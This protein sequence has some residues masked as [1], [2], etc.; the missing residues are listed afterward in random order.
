MQYVSSLPPVVTPTGNREQAVSGVHAVKPV[1]ARNNPALEV[2][3]HPPPAE[4]PH[5]GAVEHRQFLHAQDRR[6][7][8]RRIHHQYRLSDLRSGVERRR[9]HLRGDDVI[10][11]IDE[12][13]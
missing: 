12:E 13:A 8:C 9:H 10:E 6:K 1:A 5:P 7:A 2:E 11:H 4:H 3:R